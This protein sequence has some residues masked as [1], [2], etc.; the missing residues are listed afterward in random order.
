MC[1]RGVIIGT[2]ESKGIPEFLKLNTAVEKSDASL[3]G[4]GH[5]R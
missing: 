1:C 4:Y 3:W 2:V 5:V